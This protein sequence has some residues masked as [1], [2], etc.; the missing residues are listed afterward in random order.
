MGPLRGVI[1]PADTSGRRNAYMHAVHCRVLEKEL[2]SAQP[3]GRALD[4]GC[5]TGRFLARLAAHASYVCA[6]D[7]EPAMVEAA[8]FHAGQFAA[9]IEVWSSETTPFDADTFDFVL[10]SGVLCVTPPYLFDRSVK[11]MSRVL[12]AGGRLLLLEHIDESRALTEARYRG[13]LYAAGFD[14]VRVYVFR[15]GT[16]ALTTLVT[17][18]GMIPRLAYPLLATLEVA[19]NRRRCDVEVPSTYMECAIIA[20]KREATASSY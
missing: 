7:R 6:V 15:S 13:A 10:C 17:K 19:W 3:L 11:E 2:R 9:R 1:D 14:V 18:S 20:C 5:G 16:S 12:R 8:R 4:F